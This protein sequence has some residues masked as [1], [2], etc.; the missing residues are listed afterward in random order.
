[1]FEIMFTNLAIA[2]IVFPFTS[3]LFLCYYVQGLRH[4]IAEA[5]SS[6]FKYVI[7]PCFFLSAPW[8]IAQP[9]LLPLLYSLPKTWTESWLP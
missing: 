9:V 1:M 2:T 7:V 5:K 8:A 4:N 6:G 3:I